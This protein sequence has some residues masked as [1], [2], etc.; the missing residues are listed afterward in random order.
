M[1]DDPRAL[2]AEEFDQF[3]RNETPIDWQ[4]AIRM[5]V[6]IRLLMAVERASRIL[7]KYQPGIYS[8][9]EQALGALDASREV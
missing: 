4:M 2:T 8:N 5:K 9:I 1:S 7:V 6:S 3:S